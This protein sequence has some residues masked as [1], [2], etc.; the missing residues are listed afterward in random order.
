MCAGL[1][2]TQGRQPIGLAKGLSKPEC[3]CPSGQAGEGGRAYAEIPKHEGQAE[4]WHDRAIGSAVAPEHLKG[5]HNRGMSRGGVGLD[6][7]ERPR[8]PPGKRI[9][10]AECGLPWGKFLEDIDD[11]RVSADK[12]G[13]IS[14]ISCNINILHRMLCE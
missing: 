10:I 2:G 14:I 3:L 7:G 8:I 12:I 6:E 9:G 13:Y 4:P 11:G 1:Q 5:P